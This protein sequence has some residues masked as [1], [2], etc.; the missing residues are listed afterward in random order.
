MTD[1]DP[2]KELMLDTD[3]V[4]REEIAGALA[5]YVQFDPEG[6]LWIHDQFDQLKSEDKVICLL[7]AMRAQQLL[8]L[9][10]KSGTTPQELI[11]IGQMAAGTVRPK[12]SKLLKDR[13]I[14]KTDSEY[15]LPPPAIRRAVA[16]L[17]KAASDG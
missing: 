1:A 12:L 2:L 16:R 17:R 5:P 15:H 13:Q 8:G 11:E 6:G 10:E 4:A 9:R 14:A 7:L 3:D